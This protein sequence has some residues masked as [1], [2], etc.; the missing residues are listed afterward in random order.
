MCPCWYL[1]GL[2]VAAKS[3]YFYL[4]W[5]KKNSFW[6]EELNKPARKQQ[7]SVIKS[8]VFK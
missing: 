8:C 3:L 5:E 6:E 4:K 2:F 7:I 1:N